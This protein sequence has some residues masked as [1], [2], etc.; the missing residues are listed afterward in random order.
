MK[1]RVGFSGRLDLVSVDLFAVE[2]FIVLREDVVEESL[3]LNGRHSLE[4][5]QELLLDIFCLEFLL[6]E[7]L[8][9]G[10]KELLEEH[11][12]KLCIALL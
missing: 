6:A 10:G 11:H 4:V 12:I 8:L 5:L 9:L 3:Q 2:H 1:E 7:V